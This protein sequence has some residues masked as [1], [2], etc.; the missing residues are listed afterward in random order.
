[1]VSSHAP[2]DEDIQNFHC[3]EWLY[4]LQSCGKTEASLCRHVQSSKR[5]KWKLKT[6]LNCFV[7]CN[8]Y[9]VMK[10]ESTT[11]FN[12]YAAKHL[13][14]NSIR[15]IIVCVCTEVS[16]WGGVNT[17]DVSVYVCI[18]LVGKYAICSFEALCVCMRAN[19]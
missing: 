5:S 14:A 16:E 10:K 3:F 7:Y 18:N 12:I 9:K 4:Q 11:Q 19:K 15:K 1:M 8:K 13:A 17:H 2:F 6:H